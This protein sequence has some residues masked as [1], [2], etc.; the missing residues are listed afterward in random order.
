[1]LTSAFNLH[2]DQVIQ[3]GLVTIG[4]YDGVR[5]SLTAATSSGKV[6][7]HNPH[8]ENKNEKAIQYLSI[9]RN[10]SVLT[11]GNLIPST[12]S[13]KE[14]FSRKSNGDVLFI[15]TET[16]LLSYDVEKNAD[17]FYREVQDG[18]NTIVS[19]VKLNSGYDGS[20]VLVGGNCS[21]QGYDLEGEEQ[22]WTTTGGNVLSIIT[23][24]DD[25]KEIIVGS[26]DYSIYIYKDEAVQKEISETERVTSLCDM[27]GTQYG[28]ALGNGTLGIYD[29]DKRIWRTKTK[30][31]INCVHGYDIDSDGVFEIIS[32]HQNGTIEA[33]KR[34]DGTILYSDQFNNSISSI[35]QAD[36]KLDSKEELIVCSYNGE[37]RGYLPTEARTTQELQQVNSKADEALIQTLTDQKQALEYELQNYEQNIKLLRSGTLHSGLINP[38]TTVE[39]K[40]KPN[41]EDKCV[42]VVFEVNNDTVIKSAIIRAEHLFES[43]S[44]VVY[45]S[46]PKNF[47]SVGLRPK[48]DQSIEMKIQVLVGHELGTQ[49]HVFEL[50]YTMPKFSMYLPVLNF[51]KPPT[52]AVMF[53]IKERARR[54]AMWMNSSF[55]IVYK[56]NP[57][58]DQGKENLIDVKFESVR[59]G[60]GI[61]IL[62]QDDNVE[63]RV[64][65]METAGDLI[66][67]LAQ[68]MKLN[69]LETLAHFPQEFHDFEKILEQVDDF[70]KTRQ[71]LSA[72]MADSSAVVKALVI[73][74]EDSRL[75]GEMNQMRSSYKELYEMNKQLI[76]EYLKRENNH[77]KLLESLKEVN[78]MI[79]K[80]ARLR[81]GEPKTRVVTQCREAVKKNNIPS[82]FKIMSRGSASME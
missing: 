69:D 27:Q 76:G 21:I 14:Y 26:D 4:K 19:G 41:K 13:N 43:E 52:G 12:S 55:N 37:V 35:L 71:Q 11:S 62:M 47:I 42:D 33:R 24:G 34:E 44:Q 70:N 2:L 82:L 28:F 15:G 61:H 5:P 25:Q 18:L 23:K 66:H 51:S 72:D 8:N 67:D 74:A 60:S 7:V 50:N 39:C 40:L 1:M 36:Y 20:L 79:Q 54:V 59:D 31:S 38:H 6:L 46:N 45:A 9:N 17:I 63:I 65:S 3:K 80:A 49:F 68:F 10:I 64:D 81:I 73:R 32:G 56:H 22:F 58:G 57:E 16:N 48:K 29:N 30:D 53:K 78:Q 77:N 75:L